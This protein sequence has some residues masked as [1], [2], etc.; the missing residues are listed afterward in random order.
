MV[1]CHLFCQ[2]EDL[3]YACIVMEV[4]PPLVLTTS[5]S[6]FNL[7]GFL[8]SNLILVKSKVKRV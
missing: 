4:D 2:H 5:D 7:V 8:E 3:R 6:S 1:S